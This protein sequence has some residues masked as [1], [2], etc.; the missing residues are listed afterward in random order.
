MLKSS[1]SPEEYF[2]IIHL[3]IYILDFRYILYI[4]IY[5]II[6]REN[7]NR[8]ILYFSNERSED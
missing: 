3:L 5:H 2:I 7:A 1:L 6:N 8:L 4:F